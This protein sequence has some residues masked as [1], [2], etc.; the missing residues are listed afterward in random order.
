MPHIGFQQ[1]LNSNSTAANVY[2]DEYFDKF[3]A[4][5]R[6]CIMQHQDFYNQT[7]HIVLLIIFLIAPSF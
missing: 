1:K 2:G 5:K 6:V 3:K 4:L 7:S